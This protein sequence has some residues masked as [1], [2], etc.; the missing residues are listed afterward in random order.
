M[1]SALLLNVL[2]A[3]DAGR[4]KVVVHLKTQIDVVW[5]GPP[6]SVQSGI[7]WQLRPV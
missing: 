1:T 3:D 7:L 5:H 6:R 4:L 2:P